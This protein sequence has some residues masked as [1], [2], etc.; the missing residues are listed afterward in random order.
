[1][2][3]VVA[4]ALQFR[5]Q[6]VPHLDD[7]GMT[8]LRT[9]RLHLLSLYVAHCYHT[10]RSFHAKYTRVQVVEFVIE[11]PNAEVANLK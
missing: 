5:V 9:W 7:V 10:E 3:V 6:G 2:V 11:P 1:M 4:N 8:I